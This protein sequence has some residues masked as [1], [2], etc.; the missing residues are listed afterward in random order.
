[1]SDFDI[2]RERTFDRAARRLA[3]LERFAQRRADFID[4]LGLDALGSNTLC[5]IFYD[6][7]D[8]EFEIATGHIY[9]CHLVDMQNLGMALSPAA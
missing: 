9:L 4:A 2:T 5:G 6:G 7:E 8:I 3:S 1:M